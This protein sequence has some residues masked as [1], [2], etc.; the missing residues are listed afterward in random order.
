MSTRR[1]VP[2]L[3]VL[4]AVIGLT[5]IS[6]SA[7]AQATRTWVSGVGDDVNPCSRT[8]PCKTFAGAISKTA[9]NGEISVLDPGG[10]G[11]VTITK[12]IT[13]NGDGTLAGILASLVNGVVINDASTGT[14]N[15]IQVILRNLSINGAGNGLDGIRFLS[16]RRLVVENCVVFGFTGDGLEMAPTTG[17]SFNVTIRNTSFIRNGTGIRQGAAVGT[18][19]ASY[20]N[21]N[22]SENSG[23]GIVATAGTGNLSDSVVDSNGGTGLNVSAGSVW[24]VNDNVF[25][26]NV[27]NGINNASPSIVRYN[28]NGIHR[29]GT[30]IN[31]N[32]THQTFANN[33]VI[34][35]T[36]DVG[37]GVVLTNVTATN[38]K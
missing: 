4:T 3:L 31:G 11:A 32:G 37:A 28:N 1:V 13:L 34:G 21:L 8:A 14:P 35:N 38:L 23:D 5:L 27:T 25:T 24:N 17:T 7:F 30:G 19:N 9:A 12:S 6:P 22:V 2:F 15:T 36:T 16:G 10:F 20:S 33:Q 29:N 18:L 26:S